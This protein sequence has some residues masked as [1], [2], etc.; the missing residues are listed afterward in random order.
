MMKKSSN[1][2][3]KLQKELKDL[4]NEIG[5]SEKDLA[6]E[7]CNDNASKGIPECDIDENKEYEKIRKQLY[8]PTTKIYALKDLILFIISHREIKNKQFIKTP[9]VDMARYSENE[10]SFLD[11]IAKISAQI[12][13]EESDSS[14]VS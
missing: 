4:L 14:I 8:R 6:R 2:T 5:W 11:N 7:I 3:L 9:K 10:R 1:E 13:E 12:F